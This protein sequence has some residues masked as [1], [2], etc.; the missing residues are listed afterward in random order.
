MQGFP[1]AGVEDVSC[2]GGVRHPIEFGCRIPV[3]GPEKEKPRQEK[4]GQDRPG[5][6]G[7]LGNIGG[8]SILILAKGWGLQDN[9][10]EPRGALVA[11]IKRIRFISLNR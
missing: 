5:R 8:H 1:I 2:Q 6:N 9:L 3:L 10:G 4:G 11:E 7:G